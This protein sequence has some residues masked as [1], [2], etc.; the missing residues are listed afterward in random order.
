MNAEY[1]LDCVGMLDDGLIREAEEYRRP[2]RDY[3]RWITL[4]ACL[5]V[6]L[7]LG[8]GVTHIRMGGGGSA[9]ESPAGGATENR[10]AASAPAEPPAATEGIDQAGGSPDLSAPGAAADWLSAIRADGV[11]YWATNANI[12]MEPE[13][14]DIRYTTS[15]INSAE[16]E[17]D[18]QTNFLPVGRA[19]V[20]LD[21]GTAA[22]YQ[23]DNDTWRIFDPVPPW[24][25]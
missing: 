25:Q 19:Y 24:E 6:V 17:E 22:V 20:V 11:V 18:G 3:S 2:R 12:H 5:A 10:P 21:N 14:D 23:E 13:E 1:L 4:A 8:Y 15:F 7:T 9:A 16:P